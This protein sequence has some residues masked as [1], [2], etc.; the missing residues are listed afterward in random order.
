MCTV[1]FIPTQKKIHFA[2]LR[3]ENPTRATANVPTVIYDGRNTKYIAPIDPVGNGTWVGINEYGNVIVLLNGGFE[4]HQKKTTYARSRGSIVSELLA[5]TMPVIEWNLMDLENI[6]PF[7]LIVWSEEK[8]FQLVWDGMQKHRFNLPKDK[9]H[10]W[11]SSTL[12]DTEAKIY[13]QKLFTQ[14]IKEKQ[15][16]EQSSLL[17]FFYTHTDTNNGF[18]MS[19]DEKIKTLS[20]TF[21][22]LAGSKAHV[23][24]QDLATKAQHN[25]IMHLVT[26][27]Q[28]CYC[29][30]K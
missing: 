2:S 7:T 4:N 25:V 22:S 11:S 24:Y 13:R 29:N 30:T 15:L 12:Y 19:R 16:I 26:S 21:I 14:W 1:A 23:H 5:D 18:I 27:T 3:D 9:V 6:E 20:Y 10:I 8:L 17:K 28:N